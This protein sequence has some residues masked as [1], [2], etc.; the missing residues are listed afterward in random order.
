MLWNSNSVFSLSCLCPL[1]LSNLASQSRFG[2]T[3][4][5]VCWPGRVHFLCCR[6]SLDHVFQGW[7][8]HGMSN[9]PD[10]SGPLPVIPPRRQVAPDLIVSFPLVK[11][12]V[13]TTSLS[14]PSRQGGSS[15]APT[16]PWVS[17]AGL[18]EHRCSWAEGGMR[19]PGGAKQAAAQR[20][21]GLWAAFTIGKETARKRGA[22]QG[23][24]ETESTWNC[25]G[26]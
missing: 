19:T 13:A 17:T 18:E 1:W 21:F 23:Q 25:E 24:G 5:M 10:T 7:A 16:R 8:I 9:W 2:L 22:I 11:L 26:K 20:R 15:R 12:T 6:H 14:S 3:F 4:S